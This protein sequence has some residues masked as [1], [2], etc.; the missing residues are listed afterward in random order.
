MAID[1][2]PFNVKIPTNEPG[3]TGIDQLDDEVVEEQ[4]TSKDL[5]PPG[6]LLMRKP[7][8]REWQAM[9]N[10]GK[11]LLDFQKEV[12]LDMMPVLGEKRM[13]GYYDEEKKLLQKAVDE[14]DYPAIGV[15]GVGTPI[16][17]AGMWPW[18]L[19][20]TLVRP[21]ARNV[22][23]AYR[24][25]TAPFRKKSTTYLEQANELIGSPGRTLSGSRILLILPG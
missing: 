2:L 19:G 18:W 15:H 12:S 20:G 21:L 7:T 6:A 11:G 23:K 4:V 13:F 9:K 3:T 17:A 24:I 16:M 10:F 22:G 14:K 1:Q 8:N 25:A 5:P